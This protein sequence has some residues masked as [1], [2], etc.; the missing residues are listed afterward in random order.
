MPGVVCSCK[1]HRGNRGKLDGLDLRV[2]KNAPIWKWTGH[3]LVPQQNAALLFCSSGSQLVPFSQ[4]SQ[5][6]GTG[7]WGECLLFPKGWK[8]IL[9]LSGIDRVAQLAAG[10]ETSRR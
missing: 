4:V 8:V 5:R 2:L 9:R 3:G 7:E 6:Y 1:A 10:V